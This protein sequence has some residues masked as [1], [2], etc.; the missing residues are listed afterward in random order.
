MPDARVLTVFGPASALPA[1]D[2]DHLL[3]TDGKVARRD[4]KAAPVGSFN[5]HDYGAVGDGA[6]DD[7]TAFE[8]TLL[9]INADDDQNDTR[10]AVLRLK[11][12]T[13]YY[14]ADRLE[15]TAGHTLL[16]AGG[17]NPFSTPSTFLKFGPGKG[18]WIRTSRGTNHSQGAGAVLKDLGIELT[19]IEETVNAFAYGAAFTVGQVYAQEHLREF[20]YEVVTAGTSQARP[21]PAWVA[22][23]A[24]AVGDYVTPIVPNGHVYRCVVAGTSHATTEPTSVWGN[25]EWYADG[26]I[27]DGTV[28]WEEAGIYHETGHV[29]LQPFVDASDAR[30]KWTSGQA[31]DWGNVVRVSGITSCVFKVVSS[32]TGGTAGAS[33]PTAGA[34]DT[35]VSD[36]SITW[37]RKDPVGFFWKPWDPAIVI[38]GAGTYPT[39]FAGGETLTVGRDA[40]ADE[41]I[42]F[43]AGDQTKAQVI[44]RINAAFPN[45]EPIADHNG[46]A[47]STAL[48]LRGLVHGAAGEIRVVAASAPGVLTT[49]GLTVADTPG[50][51]GPVLLPR[52]HGGVHFG[53]PCDI[54]N[55]QIQG[56]EC[57][58]FHCVASGAGVVSENCNFSQLTRVSGRQG[59]GAFI[60]LRGGD[61]NNINIIG[62]RVY[63]ANGSQV[64][65][66]NHSFFDGSLTGANWV[67]CSTDA[68]YGYSFYRQSLTSY[69]NA[70]RAYDETANTNGM[71]VLGGHSESGR[72]HM[73]NGVVIGTAPGIRT[74]RSNYTDPMRGYNVIG[75]NT[76]AN[77]ETDN[78]DPSVK[79]DIEIQTALGGQAGSFSGSPALTSGQMISLGV[80]AHQ[81]GSSYE[82]Y[83]QGFVLT[84]LLRDPHIYTG[85]TPTNWNGWHAWTYGPTIFGAANSAFAVS[86]DKATAW[87]DLEAPGHLWIGRDGYFVGPIHDTDPPWTVRHRD[88]A[89]TTGTWKRGDIVWNTEPSAGGTA[90]WICTTAGTPGTWK[91]FGDIAP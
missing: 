70:S 82:T 40:E 28:T 31:Y 41:V 22:N 88:A 71:V 16:G 87:K 63:A 35:T 33:A 69:N 36:G 7:L 11:E 59:R 8:T 43:Q 77:V 84:N 76:I 37:T 51:D 67:G 10:G 38:S 89:P 55:V 15:I 49:L 47:A 78:S 68:Y 6:T 75:R 23:T 66:A 18:V 91:T 20:L 61:A 85:S 79:E 83:E 19:D 17:G 57:D 72:L 21:W 48:R 39:G 52:F 44:A 26:L 60:H 46:R 32:T 4:F 14:F 9:A 50:V 5:P 30:I 81:P 90:G 86:G 27:E 74:R 80:R 73:L 12:R 42:T 65:E 13:D 2:G 62:A 64:K 24:Y 3:T 45:D 54:E 58:Q 53:A 25:W 56:G 29:A 1:S 34:F